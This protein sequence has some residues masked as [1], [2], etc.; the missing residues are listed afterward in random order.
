LHV[1]PPNDADGKARASEV[2]VGEMAFDDKELRSIAPRWLNTRTGRTRSY[3]SFKAPS[4]AVRWWF[5]PQG[6]PRA[7]LTRSENRLVLHWYSPAQE[8]KPGAWRKLAEGSLSDF[9][10]RPVWVGEN[11]LYVAHREGPEG[12]SVVSAF[13]FERNAPA[14]E[15]LV[16]TTGFDFIGALFRDRKAERLLGVRVHTDAETTVWLDPARKAL[17]ALADAALP[18]A[19]NRMSC[20]RC[21]AD[22]AVMLVRSYSDRQPGQLWVYTKADQRWQS[23]STLRPGVEPQRMATVDFQRIKARDGR[24]LPVWLTVPTQG[25]AGG[26]RPAVVLVHGGPWVRGGYWHWSG[27]QQFLASRGYLVIEPEFRGSAGYGQAHERAG[28]KQWGK[29]MQDD[30]ADALLWAQQKGLASD[31]ACIA[32]ASYGGY[33]TLMGL[34]RH[35]TLYRCGVAWVAVTDPFLL[36]SGSWWVTDDTSDST[37][38]H[39]LPEMVGDAVKDKAMLL[40]NSPVEQAASIKAPLLLGFGSSDLRVPLQHGK[41]LRDAL[42]RAGNDPEWV[43]YDGEGHG[44]RLP[45][46]NTDFAL[47]M[48]RFLAKHLQP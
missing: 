38:R 48:E 29:S 32:G 16:R 28:Y 35:P 7:V 26:P 10:I 17:Q 20:R 25:Q 18:G 45:A 36:L 40:D 19:V 5:T 13:D 33:S 3:E 22:D 12:Y 34:V 6:E 30:V 4:D 11:S 44:W 42:Q 8:G 15:P 21:Q 31:K 1:P 37:R 14:P 23:V 9:P 39:L 41:R 2:V 27:L 47:R 46:T 43:V 24:D